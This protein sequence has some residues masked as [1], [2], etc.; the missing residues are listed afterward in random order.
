MIRDALQ[1]LGV[2][3]GLTET[4]GSEDSDESDESRFVPSVLDA[5]VQDAHASSNTGLESVIAQME[6]KA[7]LLEDQRRN[8]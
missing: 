5:S 1:R 4:A 7:R 8:R 2:R 3:L 6:E